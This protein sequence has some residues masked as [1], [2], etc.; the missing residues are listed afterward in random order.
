MRNVIVKNVKIINVFIFFEF[1]S[2]MLFKVFNF[3]FFFLI[4]LKDV[5]SFF[6]ELRGIVLINVFLRIFV[7]S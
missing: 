6:Y 2:V 5:I 7:G 3:L 4:V 1:E